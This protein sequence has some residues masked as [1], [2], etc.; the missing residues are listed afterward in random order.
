MRD[1][2]RLLA[3]AEAGADK[4]RSTQDALRVM[5]TLQAAAAEVVGYSYASDC[6]CGDLQSGT[7]LPRDYSGGYRHDGESIKWI[8]AA[9]RE[10]LHTPTE[11]IRENDTPEE[12]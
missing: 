10:R 2:Q 7:Y 1:V 5:C 9:M 6:F 4:I 3:E 12:S 11:S 8:I